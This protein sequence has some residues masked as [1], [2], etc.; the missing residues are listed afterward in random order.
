N[1]IKQFRRIATRYEKLS[2]TFKAFIHIAACCLSLRQQF[3]N[4]S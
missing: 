3:V 1:K 4:T 2:R